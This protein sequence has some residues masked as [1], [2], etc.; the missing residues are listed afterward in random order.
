MKKNLSLFLAAVFTFFCCVQVF[1]AEMLPYIP[2]NY[3]YREW[4]V[5]SPSAYT[6]ERSVSG[7]NLGVGAFVNPQGM[8]SDADGRIYIAD[9]GNNR[10][11][12]ISPDMNAP[13]RVIDSFTIDGE[14]DSFSNPSGLFVSPNNELYIADTG[15][16]RIVVLPNDDQPQPLSEIESPLSSAFQPRAAMRIIQNPE[17]DVLGNN[18]AFAPQKVAVDYADR[19][20]CV[21][22][23][24]FQGLMVF[25]ADG[26]F[27]GFFGTIEVTVTTW[28]KFW[29]FFSTQAE[30]RNQILFIPTEF[31]GIDIDNEGFV[32]ASHLAPGGMAESK[33]AVR[34]LNPKGEDVVKKGVNEHVGGDIQLGNMS[35]YSGPSNFVDIT[36]R[37]KGIYSLLDS[38]R[39]RV[40]TYDHEGNILYIF[41]GIGS[42]AG[43]FRIPAAIECAGSKILVLDSYRAEIQV[44]EETNY[45]RLINEA[46]ALRY[47]G[48]ETQAVEKWQQVLKYDENFE[49]ANT[50]IG[51]AYLTAGDNAK[52]MR[53]LEL[54]MNRDYY[55]IAFKRY[56]ND[57]LKENLGSVLTAAVFLAA[58]YFIYG[59]FSKARRA[60][61]DDGG[62]A[63]GD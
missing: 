59:Q 3:D 56:R 20:Y 25:D 16:F 19:V 29:R 43:T 63:W 22:A 38:R 13:V 10:I 57:I 39:G 15:N 49:L 62:G 21:A 52:A 60:K 26:E 7:V 40:F 55:S 48:D 8:C 31:T 4:V 2:Y 61:T 12:I 42:Q 23:G 45:G 34:R 50:G 35:I 14:T 58:A 47:D 30:R 17:S 53:Y 18:F 11:V 32:Y 41:G 24:M 33:Q 44:F 27:T 46:V 51:K 54:G 9:T 28:Q 6:P 5:Y 1:A 36:V 37:G